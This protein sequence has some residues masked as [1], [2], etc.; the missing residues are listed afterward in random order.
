MKNN[1][2]NLIL[3]A[4]LSFAVLISGHTQQQAIDA[5]PYPGI[6]TDDFVT[7]KGTVTTFDEFCV[8]NAEVT[9]RKTGTKA[10]TDSLGR[11]EILAPREDVLIF[12][13]NG[14]EKNRKLYF[15]PGFTSTT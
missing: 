15:T 10:Y 4:F 5:E 8:M 13:A 14:F 9:A 11:F 6:E 1:Q 2:L 3:T 12:K 7:V